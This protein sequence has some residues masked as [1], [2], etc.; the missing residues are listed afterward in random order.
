VR[1]TGGRGAGA[2]YVAGLLGLALAALAALAACSGAT[3]TPRT[4]TSAPAGS[5]TKPGPTATA[6]A[7]PTNTGPV[8]LAFA[9][10]V[11]FA[12]KLAPLLDHPH[13]ALTSLQPYLGGADLAMVNLETSITTRGAPEPKQFHFRAPPTALEAVQSAGID[14]VTMANNHAADYGPIGLAD[15][16]KAA[17]VSPIPVVGIGT[18][19]HSAYQ[20]HYVDLRGTRVA[21]LAATQVPD[22]TASHFAADGA[23]PGVALALSPDRLA[24]AVRAAKEEADVVVVFLHWGTDYTTCPNPLQKSTAEA[25]AAAGA[26]VIVGA[27][28]HKL[29]GA[30]WMG[31]MYVDYGLGNFV[32]WRRQSTVETWT[33]VLTLSLRDG[34]VSRASWQPMVVGASGLPQVPGAAETARLA[35][36][37]KGLRSCTGLSA[38][39]S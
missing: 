12:T 39:P 23:T 22:W 30:G 6:T 5:A 19:E 21:L 15:T 9:G 8:T 10:D 38:H 35:A 11:H 13:H 26:S 27:H 18:D 34:Q 32:W 37:W 24:R 36:Y 7:T 17:R 28:A 1:S 4:V 33:G 2:A 3:A 16:L 20:P 29:Q 14:A 31:S 25:L